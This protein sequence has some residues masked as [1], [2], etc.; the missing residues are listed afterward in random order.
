VV[1][2]HARSV[3]KLAGPRPGSPAQQGKRP[4][5]PTATRVRNKLTMWS[6]RAVRACNGALV[7]GSA[8][9]HRWQGVAGKHRWGP[10]EAPG[11]KGGDGAHRGGRAM[12][13]RRK[14][15]GAAVFNGGGVAPVVVDV[16]GGVLHHR[17][18]RGKRD[19][20]PIRGMAKLGGRSPEAAVRA[21]KRW[22]GGWCSRGGPERGW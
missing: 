2:C 11:R 1:A 12:V 18:G 10:G 4:V 15:A 5:W 9:A 17:C 21:R 8:V 6:P 3:E 22:G 16:Q 19:L 13:G 20:V 7:S 14:A